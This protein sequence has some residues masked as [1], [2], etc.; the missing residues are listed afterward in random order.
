MTSPTTSGPPASSERLQKLDEELDAFERQTGLP[1]AV[2][3]W[4]ETAAL[5]LL[6]YEPSVFRHMDWAELGEAVYTL[7]RFA[8]SLQ[9]A[10]NRQQSRLTWAQARLSLVIAP[11]L[12]HQKAYSFDERK[13]LAIAANKKAMDLEAIRVEAQTRLDRLAYMATKVAA[14]ARSL[15][16]FQQHRRPQ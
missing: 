14:L 10:A 13:L 7:E 1:Q 3:P 6:D 15:T 4:L 2:P 11:D 5:A 12:P 9:Q 16:G 8:L